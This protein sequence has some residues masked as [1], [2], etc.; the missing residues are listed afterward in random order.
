MSKNKDEAFIEATLKRFHFRGLKDI[1]DNYH[2]IV[3]SQGDRVCLG[4]KEELKESD[5]KAFD[6]DMNYRRF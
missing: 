1:K 4:C 6:R 2:Q 5:K 3:Y